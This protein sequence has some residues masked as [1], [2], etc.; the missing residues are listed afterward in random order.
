MSM[1]LIFLN[2][3]LAIN[4][5]AI[6]SFQLVMPKFVPDKVILWSR[7]YM[8]TIIF[9]TFLAIYLLMNNVNSFFF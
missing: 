9:G 3:I 2:V 8:F 7:L 4:T 6:F 5:I 1:V